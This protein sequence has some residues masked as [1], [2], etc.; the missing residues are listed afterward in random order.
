[1]RVLMVLA[2]TVSVPDYLLELMVGPTCLQLKRR[3]GSLHAV[4]AFLH[5]GLAVVHVSLW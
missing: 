5:G 4:A 2:C 3:V 1:M